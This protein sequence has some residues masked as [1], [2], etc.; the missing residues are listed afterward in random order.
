MKKKIVSFLKKFGVNH[1]YEAFLKCLEIRHIPRYIRNLGFRQSLSLINPANANETLAIT[2]K[3]YK[4]PVYLR[5]GTSDHLAFKQ[6]FIQKEYQ[7]SIPFK[8]QYLIDGGANCGY[9][10][11]YFSNRFPQA[12]IVSVE[13]ESS[14]VA[15]MKKNS[16]PYK[17]ICI[18]QGGI[19]SKNAYL[20][21]SN[22]A[23]Q[24]WSFRVEEVDKKHSEM[25][26]FSIAALM[27][28]FKLPR[29]DILK[30]DIEGSERE[31]FSK[32]Y[33]S[34]LD[35]TRVIFLELHERYAKGVTA[36]VRKRIREQKFKTSKIGEN[37]VLR[38]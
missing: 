30:L 9:A 4:Y 23:A 18:V 14:N 10:A 34:W 35:K 12:T 29:I 31:V 33:K 20:R 28:K 21:I 22:K 1:L 8:P 16:A 7:I 24:H 27:K 37:L 15:L 2:V 11:V 38:R 13:P 25:R 26:A 32:N 3:G 19:W 5:Y 36:I 6:I 17:N